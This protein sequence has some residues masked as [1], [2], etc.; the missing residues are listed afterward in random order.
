MLLNKNN[1][2]SVLD[3]NYHLHPYNTR[4]NKYISTKSHNL[5]WYEKNLHQINFFKHLPVPPKNEQLKNI[6]KITE[7]ILCK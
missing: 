1:N 7:N 2:Q 5:K 3:Y 6:K 4:T